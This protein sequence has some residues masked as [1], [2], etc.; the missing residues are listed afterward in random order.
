MN[1]KTRK[2]KYIKI[3]LELHWIVCGIKEWRNGECYA[4]IEDQREAIAR[5]WAD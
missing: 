5:G 1:R 3:R 4:E 2:Q